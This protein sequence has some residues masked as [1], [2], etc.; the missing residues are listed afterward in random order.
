M[1]VEPV[2]CFIE[3][4]KDIL[5]FN[6]LKRQLVLKKHEQFLNEIVNYKPS[7]S[8]RKW[9]FEML[10]KIAETDFKNEEEEYH[11]IGK[12][13]RGIFYNFDV[14]FKTKKERNV[15]QEIAREFGAFDY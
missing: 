15:I 11:S 6:K 13:Y 5:K 1:D 2:L 7:I 8:Y 4:D 9:L 3:N 10:K 12:F 14:A